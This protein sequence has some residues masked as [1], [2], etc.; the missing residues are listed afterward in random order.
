MNSDMLPIVTLDP[1]D[2]L[3]ADAIPARSQA[4]FGVRTSK[5]LRSSQSALTVSSM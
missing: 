5:D 2:T 1:S 4:G 3:P